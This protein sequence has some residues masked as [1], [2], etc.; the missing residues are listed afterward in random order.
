M[1]YQKLKSHDDYLKAVERYEDYEAGTYETMSL[2]EKMDFLDGVHTDNIPLFDEDGDD[3]ETSDDYYAIRDE[4]LNHPEQFSLDDISAFLELLDD[5]CYQPSFMDT[6]TEI[7]HNIV[8]HYEVEGVVYLLS[9]LHEV[10]EKGYEFGLFVNICR[11]IKDDTTY[12]FM[13]EALASVP[14]D[15]VKL[16]ERILDGRDMPEI[17]NKRKQD[18]V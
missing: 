4:F 1:S 16:I 10:P 5:S 3:M 13:K 9:H 18:L 11:L 17:I 8:R 14:S 2:K 15:T 7:I 6:V 12:Q